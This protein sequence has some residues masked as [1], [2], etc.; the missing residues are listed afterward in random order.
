MLISKPAL[1]FEFE[2]DCRELP[3]G[4]VHVE[5]ML[6]LLLLLLL[7]LRIRIACA[8]SSWGSHFKTTPRRGRESREIGCIQFAASSSL[9]KTCSVRS[10][11]K[12]AQPSALILRGHEYNLLVV[13]GSRA[14]GPMIQVEVFQE[15]VVLEVL[16]Q[17]LHDLRYTVEL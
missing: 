6:L 16:W 8:L 15:V 11:R 3:M 7:R 2:I 17:V 10:A 12:R 5:T 13:G 4:T 9:L 14:V 1:V